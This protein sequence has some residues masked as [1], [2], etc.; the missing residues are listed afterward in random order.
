MEN[1]QSEHTKQ[2]HVFIATPMYGGMCTGVYTQSIMQLQSA[3][4]NSGISASI[5]FMFNESLIT[6]ARNALTAQ[7]LK[8]NATHLLFI[9]ADIRFQAQDIIWMF[10]AD[11]DVI[12]GI[13]PKKEINW[14]T[15]ERA[16]KDNV[17]VDQLKSHTGAWV[18]NLVNYAPEITVPANQP[19]E[20]FA[21]GTGMMLIK[22]EVFEKLSDSVPSYK[23]DVVAVTE[24]EKAGEVIKEFFATS[25]EPETQRLLSEDYHFCRL[26]R[27]AGG[28]IFAAPWM[29]LGHVGTYLFEGTLLSTNQPQQ[30]EPQSEDQSA[31]QLESDLAQSALQGGSSPSESTEPSQTQPDSSN[32]D[33]TPQMLA[34][35]L[36]N[37]Y[38]CRKLLWRF[39]PGL[40]H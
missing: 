38:E 9:D 29:N 21:G 14:Y 26:W 24:L 25:I 3:F 6:R 40:A 39:L 17:P 11:K 1:N 16:V 12:C 15:V 19:V 10:Q 8:S 7:F 32:H 35:F 13:Y 4:I 31:P 5:S 23:N 2:P 22:R 20:V 34:N 27:L 30:Q 33:Q 28:Q 36:K 37:A 18:V